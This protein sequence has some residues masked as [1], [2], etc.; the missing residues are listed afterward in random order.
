VVR[1][2]T[3]CET[4]SWA[5][6]SAILNIINTIMRTHPTNSVF[7]GLTDL[8]GLVSAN[9]NDI[10]VQDRARFYHQLILSVSGEKLSAILSLASDS[11]AGSTLSDIVEARIADNTYPSALPV[12]TISEPFLSLMRVNACEDV[13]YKNEAENSITATLEDGE[14]MEGEKV[15][16]CLQY[17]VQ[18]VRCPEGVSGQIFAAVLQLSTDGPYHPCPDVY[19]PFLACKDS[20]APAKSTEKQVQFTFLPK[21][22]VPAAFR[23][24]VVFVTEAGM[25]CVCNL[26]NIEVEFEDLLQPF[27]PSLVPN[28][29][30]HRQL[31][32]QLWSRLDSSQNSTQGDGEFG[33]LSTVHLEIS[34]KEW[35]F[36]AKR[37]QLLLVPV[38]DGDKESFYLVF[39]PPRYHLLMRVHGNK[40]GGGVAVRLAT[41]CWRCLG[42]V[43]DYLHL[44]SSETGVP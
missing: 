43:S 31:F 38:S 21:Q 14:A 40:P 35:E 33:I 4:G 44:V 27:P 24:R 19:I 8:L 32:L 6:G 10:D 36:R 13:F 16:F 9:Y 29:A 7:K 30:S 26:G 18:F 23:A 41:D 37:L 5:V 20:G 34:W 3:L 39:L 15:S 2:A 22:P 28:Q 25:T 11:L 12:E 42:L 17:L 1:D